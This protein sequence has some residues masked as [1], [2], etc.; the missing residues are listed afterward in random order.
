MKRNE[1][2]YMQMNR[3]KGYC[4]CE[5]RIVNVKGDPSLYM[6]SLFPCRRFILKFELVQKSNKFDHDLR[7]L[8]LNLIG[9]LEELSGSFFFSFS[10]TFCLSVSRTWNSESE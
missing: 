5:A 8:I 7:V 6:I 9:S 10:F 3:R 1:N 4:I 2:M